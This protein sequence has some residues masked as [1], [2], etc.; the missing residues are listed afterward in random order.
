MKQKETVEVNRVQSMNLS[1]QPASLRRN[2]NEPHA[3]S[4]STRRPETVRL[5]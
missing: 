3:E 1:Q 5:K 2:S 4:A